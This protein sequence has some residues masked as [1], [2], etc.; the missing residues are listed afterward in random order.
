MSAGGSP[1]QTQYGR[2]TS[3]FLSQHLLLHL[4]I[5]GHRSPRQLFNP[6]LKIVTNGL[7]IGLITTRVKV[8][9]RAKVKVRA[10]ARVRESSTKGAILHGRRVD[11][12]RL[13]SGHL[14]KVS[15]QFQRAGAAPRNQEGLSHSISRD[16]Q[17]SQ[18]LRA[19]WLERLGP[20]L[21]N[22][23]CVVP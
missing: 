11:K 8:R 15:L 13:I 5:K 20:D 2:S 1:H 14:E 18:Q 3:H 10:K 6:M 17:A 12:Q 23:Q 22:T 7:F 16:R 4:S 19:H 21:S 9:A